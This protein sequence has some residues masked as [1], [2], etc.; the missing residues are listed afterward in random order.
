MGI[1]AGHQQCWI[2]AEKV[3]FPPPPGKWQIES[4]EMSII[5]ILQSMLKH[6][7]WIS[8][9]STDKK[10]TISPNILSDILLCLRLEY[11]IVSLGTC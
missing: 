9:K 11:Q 8:T 10:L 1:Y 4:K 5:N 6:K 7:V 2:I 3:L